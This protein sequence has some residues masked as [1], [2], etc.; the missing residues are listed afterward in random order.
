[1][2]S[3]K[4]PKN[5][6]ERVITRPE[7]RDGSAGFTLLEVVA[8]LAILM[9][10]LV[11]VLGSVS[12]GLR[13]V[14]SGRIRS[15]A[16]K[17][18]QDKMTEIEMMK[19]PDFE[20]TTEGDFDSDHPGFRWEMETVKTPDIQLM[21]TYIPGLKGMEVHLRVFFIDAGAEKSMQ[22]DTLLLE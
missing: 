21:E 20:G 17:L 5:S 18:A 11:P 10:F 14:A 7:E 9:L 8:A 19:I 2:K 16:M 6:A 1:M 3:G 12:S 22:L 13:G 15:E 4:I